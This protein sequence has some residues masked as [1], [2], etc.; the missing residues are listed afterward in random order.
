[1]MKPDQFVLWGSS[2]HAKV[3]A[4]LIGLHGGQ[5]IAL[6]DNNPDAVS[7]VTGAVLYHGK[8]G[9]REWL[10]LQNS[11]ENVGA[12]LA[13]GGARGKDRQDI[14]QTLT[15]AGLSLP[16]LV[17]PSAAVAESANIDIGSQVLANTVVAADAVI[18]K[19]CIV[20][21]SSN[22]DHECILGNGVHIAPGAVLCGCVSVGENS[23]VGAGAVVLPYIKIGKNAVVGAGA[24][25][26]RDVPDGWIVT[27][28]PA[29]KSG[30]Q[31][32]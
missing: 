17:H 6:F 26:T 21:N 19:V 4:D 32:D 20:N 24:V 1:M 3:L 18:G 10:A 29:R 13:I 9:L 11:L 23:M 22:V 30:D 28:N 12:A 27:G 5:V 2:G 14:A 15:E 25:V 16:I 7:S 31:N 8:D